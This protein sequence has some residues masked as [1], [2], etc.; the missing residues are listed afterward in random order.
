M[1][2][3][4]YLA[5]VKEFEK[6]L[7]SCEE[8]LGEGRLLVAPL[9]GCAKFPTFYTVEVTAALT[10]TS[11]TAS[12]QLVA[13]VP[14]SLKL[15]PGDV[16][17]FSVSSAFVE[18][19][20]AAAAT[21]TDTAPVVVAIEAPAA[22]VTINAEAEAYQRFEFIGLKTLPLDFQIGTE[23]VKILRDGIQGKTT[24]T[25]IS[26][27]MGVEFLLR[28]DDLGFWE[29]GLVYDSATT[30]QRFYGLALRLNEQHFITGPMETTA[31]SFQD[32][33]A[34]I[35]KATSTIVLQPT[36]YE[37]R[38]YALQSVAQKAA[39]NA[40]RRLWLLPALA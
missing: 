9:D 19:T 39:Y 13:P 40:I 31:L 6:T 8:I 35:Q 27:Q 11:V 14:G 15:N 26:P 5:N 23:D 38:I 7:L 28:I 4:Q 34:Q 29:A 22:A 30:N 16:L 12:L 18:V 36:W 2:L 32:Q 20:I 10:T 1:T 24:K 17:S 33:T 37:G 25:N 3:P 21:I